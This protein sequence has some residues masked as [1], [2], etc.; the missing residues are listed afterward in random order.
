MSGDEAMKASATGVKLTYD[1]FLLFPD[2]GQRHELIDGEHY[3]TPSPNTTHQL[4]SGNLYWLLRS[5]L[6]AHP[7]GRIFYAPFDVLF[8]HFDVVEPDLLYI[9]HE[10]AATILTEKHVRGTPELVIEIGSP[11]TRRRDETIKRRLYERVGVEEYWL[12]DPDHEMI[13]A[14]RRRG[15][16]FAR[17]RDLARESGDILTSPLFPGLEL[18]L[19][20]IFA[21]SQLGRETTKVTKP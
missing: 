19:T 15:T 18:R 17:V 12:V 4:V 3:V 16:R 13:R 8:S 20:D 9:S 11:S 5:H 2:D 1:D 6:E 10:R 14:L 7:L 21:G